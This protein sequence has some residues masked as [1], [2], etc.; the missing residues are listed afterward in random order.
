[1]DCETYFILLCSFMCCCCVQYA[2]WFCFVMCCWCIQS[3][4]W[5]F[6]HFK[7]VKANCKYVSWY[8]IFIPA[9]SFLCCFCVQSADRY[10]NHHKSVISVPSEFISSALCLVFPCLLCCNIIYC[11]FIIICLPFVTLRCC[12]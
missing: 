1:M 10:F 3:A 2:D 5:C 12:L 9:C 4:H 6:N 7:P 8:I 11:S